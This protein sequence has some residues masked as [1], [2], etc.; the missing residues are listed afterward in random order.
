MS[1]N[2]VRDK[3]YAIINTLGQKAV[4]VLKEKPSD[5]SN[6]GE[7][8][9][10]YRELVSRTFYSPEIKKGMLELIN[11]IESGGVEIW[12]KTKQNQKTKEQRIN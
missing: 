11:I 9:T 6:S 1:E 7:T 8:A 10:F 5:P 12:V 4:A 2:N 3:T